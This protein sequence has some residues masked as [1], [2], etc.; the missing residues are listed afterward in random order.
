MM[1]KLILGTVQMGL[2]YGINNKDG[3]LPETKSFKILDYAYDSEIRL[4]D[5]AEV[6]GNAHQVI[7]DYHRINPK[8]KFRIVTKI[9]ANLPLESIDNKLEE[10]LDQ[11]YVEDLEALM[12]HSYK[13]YA[14]NPMLK[15]ALS[16]LTN[17]GVIR[18]LG[19]SI[20][21]NEELEKILEDDLIDL[22]Q[23]PFNLFDN[24]SQRA[25]LL[26]EAKKKGKII[27]T[28]SAFLQGL[29]FMNIESEHSIVQKLVEPLKKIHNLCKE[30]D[31]SMPSLALRYC[32]KQSFIDKVIIGVDSL[33]QLE[34]NINA[35]KGELPEK[36][37]S[38]INSIKIENT[39][40]LN[41][42]FWP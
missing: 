13:S 25:E 17:R 14:D 36:V 15:I 12:F 8:I 32:L 40:L 38:E 18:Y 39:K 22:I 21:T 23:L 34:M 1:D 26:Q 30:L 24:Y 31:L 16:E 3:K 28:R 7:G 5:S 27:H 6:Y 37:I 11:L 33:N 35:C 41:P 19:V 4:L 29:F 20:Y 9:P 2:S 10:Y 42:S